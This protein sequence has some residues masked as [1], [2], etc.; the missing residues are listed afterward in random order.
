MGSHFFFCDA[1]PRFTD[2]ADDVAEGFDDLGRFYM[3]DSS[4]G[5]LG[6]DLG[7]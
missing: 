4:V 1:K 7:V 6:G 5:D 3:S 2:C